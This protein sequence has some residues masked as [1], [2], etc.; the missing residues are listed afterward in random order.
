[1]VNKVE[2]PWKNSFFPLPEKLTTVSKMASL[3]DFTF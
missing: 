2:G 1:M 3:K